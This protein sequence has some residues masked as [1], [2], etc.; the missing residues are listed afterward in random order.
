VMMDDN[1]GI[2]VADVSD[3][4]APVL[5]QSISLP[6]PQTM[7]ASYGRLYILDEVQGILVYD[8]R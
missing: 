3:P 4:L 8:R 1:D 5:V 2:Y 7:A 6:E